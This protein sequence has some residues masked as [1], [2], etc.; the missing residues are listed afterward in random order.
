MK[1]WQVN[2]SFFVF[3]ILFAYFGTYLISEYDYYSGTHRGPFFDYYMKKGHWGNYYARD[4]H[5]FG[6][7]LADKI[8]D[9]ICDGYVR[10]TDYIYH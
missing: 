10:L 7:T 3:V 1:Y 2:L 5:G 4:S 6:C 8:E 9:S